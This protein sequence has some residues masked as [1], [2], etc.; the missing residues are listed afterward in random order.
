MSSP[1]VYCKVCKHIRAVVSDGR[2]FPPDIAKRKLAKQ[3]LKV[4]GHEADIEYRA[5]MSQ[6]LVDLLEEM[7]N[8]H[9]AP[10]V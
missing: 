1:I 5:G 6:D 2:G 9:V 7:R 10:E 8:R 3:C 4:R